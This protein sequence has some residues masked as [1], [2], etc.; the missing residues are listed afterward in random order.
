MSN[1]T[2]CEITGQINQETQI[3]AEITAPAEI[4]V[5]IID[6]GPKGEDGYTPVKGVDYFTEEDINEIVDRVVVETVSDKTYIHD[7]IVS[8]DT[9]YV[10]HNLNKFPSVMVV[11]STGAAVVGDVR[12]VNLNQVVIYFSAQFSGQAY[13]N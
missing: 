7:Q 4:N 10:N 5:Q 12:Y 2:I 3:I 6:S 11:N 8:R 9:W 13:L 1:S